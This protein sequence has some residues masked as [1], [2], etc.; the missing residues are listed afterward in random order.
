MGINSCFRI[1]ARF[2][3]DDHTVVFTNLAHG[4]EETNLYELVSQVTEFLGYFSRN[5]MTPFP[6]TFP[7][8]MISNTDHSK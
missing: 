4:L 2:I 8:S 5:Q 7:K 6:E 3:V 1:S